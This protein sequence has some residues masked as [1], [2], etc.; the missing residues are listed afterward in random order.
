MKDSNLGHPPLPPLHARP[1]RHFPWL[2]KALSVVFAFWQCDRVPLSG[3]GLEVQLPNPR[4]PAPLPLPYPWQPRPRCSPHHGT[5]TPRASGGPRP[6]RVLLSAPTM[7]C[8]P[9]SS[10]LA[11]GPSPGSL[12]AA[13]AP[14]WPSGG[15][16]GSPWGPQREPRLWP[17]GAPMP[18][19]L[20]TALPSPCPSVGPSKPVPE[21][22]P[23]C[24][25]SHWS[26]PHSWER[27]LP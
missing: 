10:T 20:E 9:K 12:E 17:A 23:Q 8:R 4:L 25:Y 21:P 2:L 1:L 11:A 6:S 7:S 24:R 14:P 26:F 27:R 5:P 22:M 15:V 16:P 13:A 18:D 19:P 3:W